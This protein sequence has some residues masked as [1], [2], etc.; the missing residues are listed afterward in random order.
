MNFELLELGRT[1]FVGFAFFCAI[2]IIAHIYTGNPTRQWVDGISSKL[3]SSS[4]VPSIIVLLAAFGTGLVI[5]NLAER[6]ATDDRA[7]SPIADSKSRL[8]IQALFSP[9]AD[10]RHE[11]HEIFLNEL[12]A[13]N[14]KECTYQPNQLLRSVGNLL[15]S[16]NKSTDNFPR[17]DSARRLAHLADCKP[18]D[19]AREPKAATADCQPFKLTDDDRSAVFDVYYMAKNTVFLHK[20]YFEELREI[21]S[22]SDFSRALVVNAWLL[23]IIQAVFAFITIASILIVSM[24][25]R[26]LLP[27]SGAMGND[28]L[29]LYLTRVRNGGESNSTPGPPGSNQ[30][31]ER[32]RPWSLWANVCGL[33]AVAFF[34]SGG[35]FAFGKGFDFFTGLLWV[36][37]LL[38][39]AGWLWLNVVTAYIEF[40]PNGKEDAAVREDLATTYAQ[41][42]LV[43][44]HSLLRYV[45]VGLIAFALVLC[46]Y[47]PPPMG[48]YAGQFG[49]DPETG[50]MEWTSAFRRSWNVHIG[51]LTASALIWGCCF[52]SWLGCRTK[53]SYIL[54]GKLPPFGIFRYY[55]FLPHKS[56][57]TVYRQA[58]RGQDADRNV[59]ARF[60]HRV[61]HSA[62]G[63][64]LVALVIPDPLFHVRRFN[65]WNSPVHTRLPL[66]RTSDSCN[67]SGSATNH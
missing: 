21:N 62:L 30:R 36:L 7:W 56:T 54:F 17:G 48:A 12:W 23:F 9:T 66:D 53:L 38:F 50:L 40:S 61:S 4:I 63:R 52:L 51:I 2:A 33:A 57:R 42:R 67:E 37:G 41:K 5:E 39:A 25:R 35:L 47:P 44:R 3:S 14:W 24:R 27:Q 60:R 49:L 65:I 59:V 6:F 8:R 31:K 26:A 55:K 64:R 16:A 13:N 34:V 11:L 15:K 1:S 45:S 10:C 29:T 18:L 32:L 20:N 22:R 19:D 46:V 43:W 28:K 58:A